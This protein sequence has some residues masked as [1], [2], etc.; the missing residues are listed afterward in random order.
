MASDYTWVPTPEYT[1]NA[2]LTRFIRALGCGDEAELVRR[3][4]ED[5]D[6]FWNAAIAELGIRF[7]TPYEKVMDVSEGLPW[8]KWCVGGTMNFT[9]NVLDRHRGTPV[10]DK[11]AIV[12]HGED[13]SVR[14]LTYAELDGEVRNLAAGLTALGVKA[15]DAVGVYMPILPETVV[16]FLAVSRIG[17]IISPLFS[18]FGAEAIVKRMNDAGAV[19]AI[20]VD[21]ARRRGQD[22][23]MKQ[24]MDEAAAGIP[25][26][27]HMIVLR[28]TGA[29][30]PMVEGRDHDWRDLDRA[31][32]DAEPVQ[33]PADQAMMIAYTSGTTGRPKGVVLTHCGLGVK[34]ALDFHVSFDLKP[35]D[36][37]LW[38]AD[39]G[40][41]T[42]PYSMAGTLYTGATFILAEGTPDWPD[43]GRIW[44]IA[45]EHG[46]TFFGIAPTAVRGLMR[47]GPEE[48][49]KHDLSK[50]RILASTGEPWTEEAWLWF[51]E[52][53]G[54]GGRCPIINVCGG[55]EIGGGFIAGNVLNP[56]R[57]CCFAGPL[58][59]MGTDIVDGQGRPVGP[60]EVG[61]LVLRNPSIGLS[62]GIWNDPERYIETYW[63]M[64]PNLW[65]HGD[66]ASRDADG[67]WY[68]H[69]RSDDT[70]QVAG[71]RAGPAEI[72]GLVMATGK[73]VEAAAVALPDPIKGEA[74]LIAAIPA[75]GVQASDEIAAELSAAVVKGLGKAFQPK[76]ILFVDDLPK[77]RSLKIMRRVIRALVLE[78]NPGD[79]TALANPDAI[80]AVR[81]AAKAA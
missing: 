3:S 49:Q 77:T 56:Q 70:I 69:G 39:F 19:A 71:K 5:P 53:A 14:R 15:G 79:L 1:D 54:D 50:I 16:A 23:P 43:K 46:A 21:S 34:G 11:E 24:V 58:P 20:T 64:F 9:D 22:V 74:V 42:G 26:L 30:C 57:A 2:N 35:E 18:G 37:L 45:A 10:W 4:T 17:A 75:P 47:Y 68:V 61:E 31:D 63:S 66:W 80:E 33:V 8:A 48:V 60:G 55:T 6:W 12:W 51:A 52:H 59:G 67:L 40:W 36:R 65:R 73:V 72:E 7:G 38:L 62:R 13:D 78:E 29:D 32:A 28:T 27:A 76:R 41:V 81:R 44:R 25:T